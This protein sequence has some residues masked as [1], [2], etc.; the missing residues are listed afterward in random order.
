MKHLPNILT[1]LRLACP[2]YFILI[3]VLFEN[4][5]IQSLLIFYLFIILSFTDYLDGLIARRLNITS[6]FGKVFDPISDKVLASLALLFLCSLS[7]QLILPAFL[8]VLEIV[9]LERVSFSLLNNNINIKVSYLSK[10]KTTL[11]FFI[12]E[13]STLLF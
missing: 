6:N 7:S 1:T 12:L 2:F 8:I 11:Q 10:I 5:A 13:V 3:I 4:Q 9:Y